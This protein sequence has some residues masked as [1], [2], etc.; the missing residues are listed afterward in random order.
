LSL[1]NRTA[2]AQS[3]I[4]NLNLE[5]G[6]VTLDQVKS[7][8]TT[9][10]RTAVRAVLTA[11]K[12]I[13]AARFSVAAQEKNQEAEKKRYENGISTSFRINQIQDDLT[14]ARSREVSAIVNYRTSLADYYKAIGKL[15]DQHNV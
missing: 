11:A 12:Q 3:L 6:R 13:D 5:Q 1:E 14:Q 7:Q 8:I 2:R 9:E 15:L 4:A 10:V